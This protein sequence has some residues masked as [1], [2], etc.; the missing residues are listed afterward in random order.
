MSGRGVLSV[1][2]TFGGISALLL[3][4]R[5]LAVLLALASRLVAVTLFFAVGS[6]F[7]GLF[8]ILDFLQD[9]TSH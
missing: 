6:L 4:L 5:T 3:G 1:V 7:D 8:C 2:G 9:T